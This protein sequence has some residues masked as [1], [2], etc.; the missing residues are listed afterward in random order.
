MRKAELLESVPRIKGFKPITDLISLTLSSVS[1]CPWLL[2]QSLQVTH[3]RLT[4]SVI[5]N[6]HTEM[7]GDLTSAARV[8]P[9][10]GTVLIWFCW[11][12]RERFGRSPAGEFVRNLTRLQCSDRYV[13][14]GFRRD[15]TDHHQLFNRTCR[16]TKCQSFNLNKLDRRRC[17]FLLFSWCFPI[18][19]PPW[20]SL[21]LSSHLPCNVFYL[22]RYSKIIKYC[23]VYIVTI[24]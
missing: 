14:T 7:N 23:G 6:T 20:T 9:Q 13:W 24:L 15:R 12:E 8:A 17:N 16:W 21:C 10:N 11:S 1:G 4:R 3:V 2:S 18:S 19:F 22:C 5:S